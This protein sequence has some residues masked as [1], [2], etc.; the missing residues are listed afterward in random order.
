MKKRFLFGFLMLALITLL[1]GMMQANTILD[2]KEDKVEIAINSPPTMLPVNVSY[3]VVSFPA[4]T[5]YCTLNPGYVDQ[6]SA[7]VTD[8][9]VINADVLST[10]Y[11]NLSKLNKKYYTVNIRK[12]EAT[13][14]NDFSTRENWF[15]KCSKSYLDNDIASD[16]DINFVFTYCQPRDGLRQIWQA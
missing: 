9:T 14:N 12:N 7:N 5:W 6:N 3:V 1:S 8:K 4:C 11:I 13:T 16:K 10:N 2:S 15:I